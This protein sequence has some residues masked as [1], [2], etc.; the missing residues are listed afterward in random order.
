M[1]GIAGQ[2]D[3]ISPTTPSTVER[4]TKRLFHRGPDA[5]GVKSLGP[6]SFGHTRLAIID[7]TPGGAQPMLDSSG[8]LLVTFNGEIYNHS[9]LRTELSALGSVF[10]SSSDTE[11]LL[12]AYRHWGSACVSRFNGMFAFA[13][14]DDRTQTLL[15]ARDRLGKKPLYYFERDSYLSF[16]SEHSALL[17][18]PQIPDTINDRAIIQFLALGYLTTSECI[19][20]HIKRLPPGH[21]LEWKR[22]GR[23]TITR[24]WDLSRSFATKRRYSNITEASEELNHLLSD[25]VKLRL[26]SDVPLGAFL[27][28]GIDSS[29]IVGHMTKFRASADCHTFSLGFPEKS[30][31]ELEGAAAIAR[32]M[33]V[34]HHQDVIRSQDIQTL[35]AIAAC[36][37][38][39]FADTSIIPM[40]HL[41]AFAR[42][43]VTV[44]LSGDGADEIFGGYETYIA[45]KLSRMAHILPSSLIRSFEGAYRRFMKRD[46][47]KVS[48][49]YKILHFLRGCSRPFVQSHFSWRELFS[50]SEI[51]DMVTPALCEQ[52]DDA[53]PL[54]DFEKFDAEVK[55]AHYLDRAMYIDIKTWLVDDILVKV[56]RASMAHAL[57]ARAPF[58]DYRLV[59]FAASLPV[60][61][62]VKGLSKKHIL[63]ESQKGLLDKR[64]LT[65]PKRGFNAPISHWLFGELKPLCEEMAT[66]GPLLQYLDRKAIAKTLDD[67]LAYR[68]D[69]SFKLFAL[70]Q[71]HLFL[72]N[73]E[74]GAL[75][76]AA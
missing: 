60:D 34:S 10:R 54:R 14:W 27:S 57:E 26:M 75:G 55:D 52:I 5:H 38:E 51:T 31:S 28:G 9:E 73:R 66:N 48:T 25:A 17:E 37:G 72:K 30:F 24:Y 56:D 40:Y 58:L 32:T 21:T 1:C 18:D 22:G 64:V 50:K 19:N 16:A 11:V 61:Y 65:Q 2:I 20:P 43:N 39:P 12:E 6:I 70:I 67:H 42:K 71:L 76:K 45:D 41:S 15:L 49:D 46:F 4:I 29:T 3:W 63:K 35:R 23:P 69:N 13:L 47:G 53:H 68:S 74:E 59:E 8:T 44:T 36:S 33:E 7:L 62:K